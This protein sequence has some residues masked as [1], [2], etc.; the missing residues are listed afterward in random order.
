MKSFTLNETAATRP[1]DRYWQFCVGSGHAAL[2]LR[3]DYQKQLK[4]AHDELGF[5]RVRFHGIFDDDMQ[6]IS[7]FHDLMPLPGGKKVKTRSFYQIAVVYDALLE[8]G[9][10]PFVELGFMPSAIARGKR[11]VFHYKGNVTPPSEQDEWR[12][13]VQDFLRFLIGRYGKAEVE[14]WYF[15]VWN[16]PDLRGFFW[17]GTQEEY[18]LLYK[19]TVNAIKDI[20]P[21][22][23]VGGPATSQNRWLPE[24]RAYCEREQLP[25]DFLSTHHYPGDD[26]GLPIL[27]RENVSRMLLAAKRNPRD[28]IT[29]VFR[30]MMYRPQLLP[31]IEKDS[32]LRQAQKARREAG[33]IPLF[34]TEWNVNPTCTA[35]PHDTT[36]SSAYVVKHVLDCQYLMDGCSFWCFSDIFEENSFLPQPFT[37]SFGFMNIYGIP[38]PS[39]WAFYLL[40]L[41]GDERYILPATHEEI[42]F[43]AFRSKDETQLLLYHQS[44]VMREGAAEPVRVTLQ[45]GRQIQSVRRWRIDRTHGNPLALW[46]EMGGP[47]LLTPAQAAELEAKSRLEPEEL[48]FHATDCGVVLE[49]A[50]ADNDVQLITILFKKEGAQV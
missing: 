35:P 15:E 41:L 7:S 29:Q 5:Q 21:N 44:Y 20:D 4:R 19:T 47:E 27:S 10:K 25:L 45:T 28:N 12:R 36:Q 34:Y 8:M 31:L 39:F 40:N 49:T 42:E 17:T 46:E 9:V 30:K 18:F 14:S 1:N 13:L 2:A 32:M 24:M 37:G 6:V 22:I 11:T 26:V 50:L 43:A 33:E 23:R 48:P 38:K 16:E 3:A